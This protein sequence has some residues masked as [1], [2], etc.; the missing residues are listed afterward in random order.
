M[1]KLVAQ[2]QL[3]SGKERLICW[4]DKVGKITP[5]MRITL[6]DSDDPE[7]WWTIV[8]MSSPVEK[9]SIKSGKAFSHS[10]K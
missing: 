9:S 2:C 7:K 10:I 6:K 3:E 4:L 1:E 8:S 5:G